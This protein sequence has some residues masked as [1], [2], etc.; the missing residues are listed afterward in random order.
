MSDYNALRPEIKQRFT[1]VVNYLNQTDGKK[2][3]LKYRIDATKQLDKALSDLLRSGYKDNTSIPF[4]PKTSRR[5][6]AGSDEK[7]TIRKLKKKLSKYL[8]GVKSLKEY[9][10]QLYEDKDDSFLMTTAEEY[11]TKYLDPDEQLAAVFSGAVD[12][13]N[14]GIDDDDPSQLVDQGDLKLTKQQQRLRQIKE[15]AEREQA[16]QKKMQL[17]EKNMELKA[18]RD[19]KQ[20][21]LEESERKTKENKAKSEIKKLAKF[22]PE[23][24]VENNP[25]VIIPS[26]PPAITETKITGDV[27]KKQN[28]EL[29]RKQ[30]EDAQ[31]KAGLDRNNIEQL[32]KI[33]A[34]NKDPDT[35][36]ESLIPISNTIPN[37][38]NYAFDTELIKEIE[39]SYMKMPDMEDIF[40]EKEA[41]LVI[42][43]EAPLK[44]KEPNM[45]R[46][47]NVSDNIIKEIIAEFRGYFENDDFNTIS[48][49]GLDEMDFQSVFDDSPLIDLSGIDNIKWGN[50]GG[51]LTS[52]EFFF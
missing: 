29:K 36:D 39:S 51:G 21:K 49:Q 7:T 8:D 24:K 41:P 19:L 10:Q 13:D 32:V 33:A 52:E 27:R 15:Q 6:K 40:K 4:N 34:K 46:V 25:R 38:V 17:D 30:D 1:D 47:D 35:I 20:Q 16:E 37:T 44:I 22:G 45:K 26:L 42:L 14:D 3:S 9:K 31:I 50:R 18:I 43:Q 2:N 12:I 11:H 48:Y 5:G 23:T 28:E